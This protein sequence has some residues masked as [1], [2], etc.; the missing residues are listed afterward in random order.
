MAL[1]KQSTAYTRMFLMVDS[2]D[3]VT[4]KTGLTVAVTLS[5][6]GGTF[7]SAGGTITEVSSGFYKI[8]LTTTD[9]NTLGEL[10]YHCTATGADPTDFVDQVSAR[11]TD[12][13]AYPAT[14]GRSMVVDASGLVD[15]CTV[16]VG[17]SGSGTAQTARDLGASVLISSGT[18]TGQLD[19]TSGVIKANLAQILGTALTE[20]AGQIAN[21]FKQFFNIA[22]PTST[23]NTITTVTTATNLT[24][25]NDK[26]GYALTQT[27][28]TNFSAMAITAGGAVTA[29]TVSDKTG[30]TVST[31]SDKTGYALSSAGVQAIWDALTS[32]L[33][34]ASSIGK[35][36]AD[37]V[38]G[39][40][41]KVLLSNNAQT[42]VTIPTVTAVTNGV[43]VTTNNDKTGYTA[44]TV[45]DKTGYSLTQTFPTNFA[46]LAITAST[47]RVT[48][49]TNADK[50]GYSI[51]G[52]K[53]TL[54]ALNDVSTTQ[55]KTQVTDALT[56][57]TYSQLSSVPSASTAVTLKTM[58]QFLFQYFKFKRTV[59]SSTETLLKADGSTSLATSTV[60][61]NGTTFTHGEVA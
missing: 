2:T 15:A 58:L 47:G 32:A 59:T 18:G 29:G 57:D 41:S 60:S 12:D 39:S 13:L 49:G 21:G 1:L 8:A 54:D 3:H 11:I 6:A 35:K 37:W 48:V 25:N 10:A 22:S 14:S 56:V 44:S 4:G 55:V 36:L 40:D 31:V 28:P 34:T 16:K 46:D 7:A 42:G 24:T 33:T 52:T 30:Y 26:T 50:S 19:V 23:M 51:S 20:T 61:D 27:F 5:K 45:S 38:L 53:T 43:T 9:T 17:A